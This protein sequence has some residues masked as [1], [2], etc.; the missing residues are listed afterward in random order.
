MKSMKAMR[1]AAIEER[2]KITPGEKRWGEH[3]R[4]YFTGERDL[5]AARAN[6]GIAKV[7]RMT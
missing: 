6:Q 1:D 3:V 5:W 7:R 2:S 4:H